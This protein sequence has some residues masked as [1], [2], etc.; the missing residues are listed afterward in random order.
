[1][2][3]GFRYYWLYVPASMGWSVRGF[4]DALPGMVSSL[5]ILLLTMGCF[6]LS[7][8]A[9]VLTE[10][11]FASLAMSFGIGEHFMLNLFHDLIVI[12]LSIWAYALVTAAT[13]AAV[14]KMRKR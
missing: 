5:R 6:L 1:M 10:F 11:I 12:A 14:Q 7:G 9:I 13:A 4:Y 8:I 3:Y 2:I